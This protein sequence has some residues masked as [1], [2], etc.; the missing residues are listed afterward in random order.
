MSDRT[1]YDV[2]ILG[3]GLAGLTLARHLLLETERTVLLVEKRAEVPPERQ[4]VGESLVQLAGHY[5]AK[6]LDLED[7]LL[8][9]HFMKYNLRFYW[10]GAGGAEEE[11][12][13]FEEYGQ[14]FI[15][16]FSN[17]ASYQLDRNRLEA[18][19]VR[20]NRQSPRFELVLGASGLDVDLAEG[21]DAHR[22]AFETSEG[23]RSVEGRWVVDTT[24]RGKFLARRMDLGRPN[25][26][27][28]G[29][30]FWWV[31]GQIDLEKLT[32]RSRR[33]IRLKPERAAQG[34]LPLW[35]ATNH[36]MGEGFWFWVIPLQG[37]TSLGLVFDRERIDP[38][39][40]FSVEKATA[41]VCRE[42]PLFSHVLPGRE[43][44]DFGGFRS[45]SYDCV[46]TISP[47][48]WA[49]AGESGRF[50]D[51]LYSPGSDLIAVHNTL[52]VA[53][54]ETEDRDELAA[55]CRQSEQLMRA[56][57]GAYVPSYAECYDA[58]GDQEV[59]S[60]K[61]VWELSIYF[62][63]YVFPFVNELLTDRRFGLA[64]LRLFSRLGPTNRGLQSFLSD[65]Y[66]WKRDNAR[67]AAGEPLFF[68]FM[69]IGTLREAETTFYRIGVTVEEAKRELGRQVESLEELA[70]FIVAHAASVVLD[71][72][73]VR[74][75]RDFVEAIDLAAIRFDPEELALRWA[76]CEE[77][78][79]SAAP[80][81]PTPYPWSFDPSVLDRFRPAAGSIDA[82]TT[83]PEEVLS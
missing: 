13:R 54:I 20:R 64:F 68:D 57:Y 61:Y 45:F 6:V 18:E 1:T 58:L 60:L 40:V 70:R 26:I 67:A 12:A 55:R 24:G 52:I 29:A 16:G 72:P 56:V 53:A 34:H 17:V 81:D 43:V 73:R 35:L 5:F 28:H 33:E 9:D 82:E 15:R 66:R 80:T 46:Q 4:K 71:E 2:V 38:S 21:D 63:F 42:L 50:S 49:L 31:D 23:R 65:F 51:P 78:R 77:R 3:A 79:R 69:E 22:L 37:K 39:D 25:A 47:D 59:F 36:F 74:S 19:L 14:S 83:T 44:L 75:D 27:D 32:D 8:T 62:A 41:W 30:F 7:H 48:R 76:E 10:K 11:G